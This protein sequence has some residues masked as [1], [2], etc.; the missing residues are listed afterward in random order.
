[1]Q[2]AKSLP[3]SRLLGKIGAG[4]ATLQKTDEQL[5]RRNEYTVF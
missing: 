4:I 2:C 3:G 1:L 5:L